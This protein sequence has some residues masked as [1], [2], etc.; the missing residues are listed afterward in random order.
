VIDAALIRQNGIRNAKHRTRMH[1]ANVE[2]QTD[3]RLERIR[4]LDV[5]SV[6]VEVGK[7]NAWYIVVGAETDPVVA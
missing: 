7:A 4:K 5:P 2:D 1:S 3:P 6:Q